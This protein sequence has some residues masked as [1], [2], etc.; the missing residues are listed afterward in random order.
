MIISVHI[1]TDAMAKP[2][3]AKIA[4]SKKK[5][6]NARFVDSSAVRWQFGGLIAGVA[7]AIL[8]STQP[9]KQVRYV[10][11]YTQTADEL[12]HQH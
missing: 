11:P 9:G 7:V 3:V 5:K 8:A 1:R 2:N 12:S 10:P 6:K 4:A